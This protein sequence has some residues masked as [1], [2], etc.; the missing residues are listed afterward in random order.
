MHVRDRRDFLARAEILAACGM[1]MLISD[2]FE[3]YRPRID[4]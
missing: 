1:T 3:Y 4:L 2:Y